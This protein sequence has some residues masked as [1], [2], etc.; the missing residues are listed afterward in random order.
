[1][2]QCEESDAIFI[3]ND[4]SDNDND[5]DNSTS[6]SESEL[7]AGPS[8]RSVSTTNHF[9][10]PLPFNTNTIQLQQI[11]QPVC[12]Y[13]AEAQSII[14][15]TTHPPS[16]TQHALAVNKRLQDYLKILKQNLE[17]LLEKCRQK[18]KHNEE[19][20]QRIRNKSDKLRLGRQHSYFLCGYPFFKDEGLFSAPPNEHYLKRKKSLGE[21]FPMDIRDYT[22]NWTTKDKMFLI[23]GV[24]SQIIDAIA[25]KNR[26]NAR[27][28]IKCTRVG[29]LQ[30]KLDVALRN[31]SL[32]KLMLSDLY[33]MLMNQNIQ[34]KI[35]WFTIST[36]KLDD[37]HPPKQCMALWNAYLKPT[38]NRNRWTTDEE[39]KLHQIVQNYNYQN[40][41]KIAKH[42][43]GRSGYQCFVH[44][45]SVM[46]L[47]NIQR[48]VR[49]TPEEDNLLMQTIEKH[50]IGSIIPWS[51]IVEKMPGRTKTQV[52][53]R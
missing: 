31:K 28:T 37:R 10:I 18:Y 49:F 39:E 8:Q 51:T 42:L 21:L 24:K 27:A 11:I 3:R 47:M 26:D 45:Q 36:E 50:R 13:V 20:H 32:E 22:I 4:I 53:N 34:F 44:Y 23:Q 12:N 46:A 1:M 14:K 19:V 43:P 38:L 35:D 52:Y 7:P 25:S 33:D 29:G 48:N 17:N 6:E 2:K 41:P 16:N 40:W 15:S 30:K 9:F 5:Y